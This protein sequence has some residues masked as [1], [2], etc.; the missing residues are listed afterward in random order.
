M[1]GDFDEQV[2]IDDELFDRFL[3]QLQQLGIKPRGTGSNA[4]AQLDTERQRQDYM[5]S[6]FKSALTRC[7]EDAA[8]LPHGERMDALAGQAIVFARLAGYI[9]AQFP[10]E[11]DLF[12]TI[13]TAVV[14]GYGESIRWQ[15]R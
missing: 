8:Q 3:K 11:S 1:C 2:Q 13:T 14:D 15:Q 5:D 12:R 6:F 9:T 7:L 10:P 4:P